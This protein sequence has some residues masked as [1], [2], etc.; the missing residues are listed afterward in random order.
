MGVLCKEHGFGLLKTWD[1]E[2]CN[3]SGQRVSEAAA[4]GE[5]LR[6]MWYQHVVRHWQMLMI[7]SQYPV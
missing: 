7:G 1:W 5:C 3:Q 2:E 6:W 4:V